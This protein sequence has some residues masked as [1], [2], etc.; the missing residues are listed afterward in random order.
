MLTIVLCV[1][2]L[3]DFGLV[4]LGSAST[5][6]LAGLFW[7]QVAWISAGLLLMLA[8]AQTDYKIWREH[9]G[10]VVTIVVYLL[11]LVLIPH[12]GTKLYGARRSFNFWGVHIEPASLS[13]LAIVIFLAAHLARH[14]RLIHTFRFWSV[15]RFKHRFREL[16]DGVFV[17]AFVMWVIVLLL[18]SEPC[19]SAGWLIA[20]VAAI[21][22]R[23]GGLRGWWIGMTC[24]LCVAGL[25]C[26]VVHSPV[27]LRR[28]LA[29][30]ERERDPDYVQYHSPAY[31]AL[32]N[33][34][35]T[36]VSGI[37]QGQ[38]RTQF[39]SDAAGDFVT[40]VISEEL[41]WCGLLGMLAVFGVLIVTGLHISRHAG[42]RFGILLGIGIVSLIG[43]Q[44]LMNVATH[45]GWFP[46]YTL[47]VPFVGYGGTDLCVM[48]TGIGLLLSIARHAEKDGTDKQQ[49]QGA[50]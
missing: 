5:G 20:V 4:M 12:V 18:L 45:L 23:V 37:G 7:P 15:I 38:M 47:P 30:V 2:G 50:V 39:E 44:M 41:G 17:P 22:L 6:A 29:L 9:A 1:F 42:D 36:G 19:F 14:G 26:L 49:R 43:C 33:C 27:R 40:V 28:C 24:A 25:V 46:G 48:L 21:V 32:H 8:A 34:G 31:L 11:V 10:S 16:Y 35:W 3:L 13:K